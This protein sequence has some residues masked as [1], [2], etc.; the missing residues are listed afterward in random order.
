MSFGRRFPRHAVVPRLSSI[1]SV[2]TAMWAGVMIAVLAT[3][4]SAA[5]FYVDNQNPSA[6][7]SNPGTLLLPYRTIQ[8][9]VSATAI[10]G[11]TVEVRPGIYPEQVTLKGSGLSGNPFVIRA[12]GPGVVVEGTD[13]FSSDAAWSQPAGDAWLAA[14]V[15]WVVNQAFVD[16]VRYLPSTA[17]TPDKV[18][19]GTFLYVAGTGLYLNAGGDNPGLHQTLIG[20]RHYGFY[21]SGYSFVQIVGFHVKRSDSKGIYITGAASSVVIRGNSVELARS[22]GIHLNGGAFGIV[23]ENVVWNGGDHGIYLSNGATGA[24]VSRNES[25][26]NARPATRA[27]NGIQLNGSSNCRIER[28]RL[29][30][31]QDSGLQINTSSNNNTCVQNRSWKN[32]DHGYDH[33]SSTGTV[34][35]GDLAYGNYKDG[36]SFEGNA[37]GGKM[38]D[39]IS[40]DNGLTTN[41]YNLW[42][43]TSSLTGFV[44]DYNLIWNSTSQSPVKME[45]KA[46]ASLD[47]YKLATGRD[48]NSVSASPR[49]V[50]APAGDFRLGAGSAAIDAATS[51]LSEWQALDADGQT[52][53]DDLST[54]NKGSGPVTYADMGPLEY[55][56]DVLPPPPPPI[57][58]APVVTAPATVTIA[59]GAT[60]TFAVR[61]TDTQTITTF[62]AD[63]TGLPSG[64]NATFTRSSVDSLATFRWTPSYT[65]AGTYTVTFRATNDLTG[66]ASTV[67][68]VTNTDRAPIVTVPANIKGAVG[69]PVTFNVT[70]SDPDGDPI[71]S[72]SANLS[73]L[74]SGIATFTPNASNTGGLFTWTALT[75]ANVNVVF[76]A[77][78]AKTG[79][80]T[81]HIQIRRKATS[82]S[83][84]NVSADLP[85]VLSLSNAFPNPSLGE[86]AFALALPRAAHVE[87][88]IFDLQ[89]RATRHESMESA[90]GRT[91]LRWDGRDQTGRRAAPGIY[92][93]RVMAENERFVRRIT[94]R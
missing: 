75:T 8:A 34:H 56:G 57:N 17:T 36:F 51:D 18:G 54:A 89:G 33:L 81:A 31:N 27:A 19:P 32:G 62:T 20:R 2:G 52:R 26:Q 73:V 58:V 24:L 21:N 43:D 3:S 63:L 84:T 9:A 66:T 13:S 22:N 85:A 61:A 50:D 60:L 76:T 15:T 92:L 93:V 94:V 79:T 37:P 7:D 83:P 47:A 55:R 49:F 30:D 42:V 41:E 88:T 82:D 44:S 68:T 12:S 35:V 16:G 74:T 39:C 69:V 59:E 25:Y 4:A 23:S 87:W 78:N 48:G 11:N 71:S 29:H 46:Y 53:Y 28:N 65:H 90:A 70:A 6:S 80:G 67:I 64:N 14:G 40:V 77:T 91:S 1:Q 86:V 10:P 45:K 5:T 72:L 38:I